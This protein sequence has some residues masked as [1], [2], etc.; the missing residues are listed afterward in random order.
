MIMP[1]EYMTNRKKKKTYSYDG[2]FN[3]CLVRL[4][5]KNHLFSFGAGAS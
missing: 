1:L 4:F 5:N 3:R 2:Y